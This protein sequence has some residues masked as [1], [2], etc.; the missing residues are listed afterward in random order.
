MPTL[1]YSML[2]S[3]ERARLTALSQRA[4]EVDAAVNAIARKAGSAQGLILTALTG[5][6]ALL[7]EF[8]DLAV[9]ALRPESWQDT[10]FIH[11]LMQKYGCDDID[12][13]SFSAQGIALGMV[14]DDTDGIMRYYQAALKG[15]ILER[16]LQPDSRLYRSVRQLVESLLA[17][18]RRLSA[19]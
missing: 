5:G 13:R 16:Y 3:A 17:N 14:P 6:I 10:R 18:D 8:V 15:T 19:D 11:A 1:T 4:Q 9:K 2:D 7:P 12:I